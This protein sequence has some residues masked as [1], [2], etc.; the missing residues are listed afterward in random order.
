MCSSL[1][2]RKKTLNSF[3]I[4][5]SRRTS[6]HNCVVIITE[7]KRVKSN[8]RSFFVR[9]SFELIH[10]IRFKTTTITYIHTYIH[11]VLLS[12]SIFNT[13]SR[14]STSSLY[15]N[16]SIRNQI[17]EYQRANVTLV[18]RGAEYLRR[19]GLR[20]TAMDKTR[21]TRCVLGKSNETRPGIGGTRGLHKENE[22][23]AF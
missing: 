15:G 22:T 4:M 7:V 18:K 23:A 8:F 10:S 11:R 6:D 17:S 19:L 3:L 1:N 16:T 14:K 21:R 9:H 13:I 20:L 5:E 12:I 2:Q